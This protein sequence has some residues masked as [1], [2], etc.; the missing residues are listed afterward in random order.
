[1]PSLKLSKEQILEL[2]KQLSQEQKQWLLDF[3]YFLNGRIYLAITDKVK[4]AAKERDYDWEKM[5]ESN[6]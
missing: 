4:L 2:V 5:S 3:Y 1:M 6:P